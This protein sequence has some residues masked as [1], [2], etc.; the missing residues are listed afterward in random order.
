M[1]A[2]TATTTLL[3]LIVGVIDANTL[4]ARCPAMAASANQPL[5]RVQIAHI[6]APTPP[7]PFADQAKAH[8]AEM[9]LMQLADLE[10][11]AAGNA[12]PKICTVRV[13]PRSAPEGPRTLDVGLAMLS[14]GMARVNEVPGLLTQSEEMRGQYEFAQF[15]A[16]ARKVGVRAN[17]PPNRLPPASH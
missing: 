3:C 6:T 12:E 15:E 17:S 9:T 13:T 11:A 14:V 10:C 5:T 16:T 8:L 7:E 1:L 2:A 4:L